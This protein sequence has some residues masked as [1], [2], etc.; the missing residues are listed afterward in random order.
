M[1]VQRGE[2]GCRGQCW[3][4]ALLGVTLKEAGQTT[5]RRRRPG[6]DVK[7]AG[8]AVSR[9]KLEDAFPS[10]CLGGLCSQEYSS[11]LGPLSV[12]RLEACTILKV[13][14]EEKNKNYEKA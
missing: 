2:A 8:V 7:A 5:E 6:V 13:F 1:A 4:L 9:N 10:V 14:F 12:L 3:L 11:S